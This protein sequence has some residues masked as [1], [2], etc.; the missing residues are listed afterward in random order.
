MEQHRLEQQQQQWSSWSSS[1]NQQNCHADQGSETLHCDNGLETSCSE[2]CTESIEY[3]PTMCTDDFTYLGFLWGPSPALPSN[4]ARY[5]SSC[6]RLHRIASTIPRRECGQHTW[7]TQQE[8]RR[9]RRASVQSVRLDPLDLSAKARY[10]ILPHQHRLHAWVNQPQP[11][12]WAGWCCLPRCASTTEGHDT[13]PDLKLAAV[14]Q[15]R[16]STCADRVA[17]HSAPWICTQQ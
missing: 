9:R 7:Y 2:M 5:T 12:N 14:F 3:Q 16:P 8:S 10:Q 11:A 15:S 17:H 4:V 1:S 13:T 6:R